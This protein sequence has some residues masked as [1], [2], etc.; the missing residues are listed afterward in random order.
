MGGQ[1]PKH[2]DPVVR[3]R[4]HDHLDTISSLL[5]SLAWL[6]PQSDVPKQQ[7]IACEDVKPKRH[8]PRLMLE[9]HS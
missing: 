6:P 2:V 9:A 8:I 3:A 5:T 4:A 1:D 7:F